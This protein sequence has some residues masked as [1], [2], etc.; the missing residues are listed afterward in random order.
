MY[1]VLNQTG[2]SD[3]WHITVLSFPVRYGSLDLAISTG[4]EQILAI[5]IPLPIT[6]K[7]VLQ[8]VTLCLIH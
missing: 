1:F 2:V 5:S 8:L 7:V 4:F 6:L 3:Q